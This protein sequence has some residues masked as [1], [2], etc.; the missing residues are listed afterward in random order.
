MW[1]LSGDYCPVGDSGVSGPVYRKT[2]FTAEE[3]YYLA[4]YHS[5][6]DG[7]I[8]G[9][10]SG[11]WVLKEP[12]PHLDFEDRENNY[13]EL[14]GAVRKC[15]GSKS[16]N[17][18]SSVFES[19]HK[20]LVLAGDQSQSGESPF[21]Q[22][23]GVGCTAPNITFDKGDKEEDAAADSEQAAE[24]IVL[25]DP[26]TAGPAD[27]WL[28]PCECFPESWGAQKPVSP[29]SLSDIPAGSGNKFVPARFQILEGSFTCEQAGLLPGGRGVLI[30]SEEESMQ[31][32]DCEILCREDKDCNYYWTGEVKSTK[33][34]RLFKR[35]S[36]LI[37][38]NG[39]EGSLFALPQASKKYCRVADPD[40][41]W[42]TTKR[43]EH[44]GASVGAK[45]N[46]PK[47][48]YEHLVMQCDQKLLLGGVGI[49]MCS[50]CTYASVNSHKW[51]HKHTLPTH[52]QHGQTLVAN[53]WDERFASVPS[54]TGKL[55]KEKLKCV[56]GQWLGSSGAPGLAGFACGACVQL[57]PSPYRTLDAQ[58]KQELYFASL[59]EV[60][61]YIDSK[62]PMQLTRTGS[63]ERVKATPKKKKQ[64]FTPLS[65]LVLGDASFF[66]QNGNI[67]NLLTTDDEDEGSSALEPAGSEVEN[68]DTTVDDDEEVMPSEA[69][70]DEAGS[71]ANTSDHQLSLEQEGHDEEHDDGDEAG[72]EDTNK[73]ESEDKD[74]DE[75]AD[76]NED[77]DRDHDEGQVEDDD[78]GDDE[79]EGGDEDDEDDEDSDE[80]SDSDGDSDSEPSTLA[81]D[82]SSRADTSASAV[83][84][85]GFLAVRK[86]SESDVESSDA[87]ID[88][89]SEGRRRRRRRRKSVVSKVLGGR[90]RRRRKGSSAKKKSKAGGKKTKASSKDCQGKWTPWDACS[91]SCGG[92]KQRSTYIVKKT[93]SRGGKKCPKELVKV[94]Q[95][96]MDPCGQHAPGGFVPEVVPTVAE[97]LKQFESTELVGRCL[98]ADRKEAITTK[99]CSATSREQLI[100]ASSILFQKFTSSS[101]ST[102]PKSTPSDVA[103]RRRTSRAVYLND[104]V[105][106]QDCKDHAISGLGFR[107]GRKL[108]VTVRCTAAS[109]IGAPKTFRVPCLGGD[110][111]ASRRDGRCVTYDPK[112]SSMPLLMKCRG[113]RGQKWYWSGENLKSEGDGSK[114]LQYNYISSRRRRKKS[115]NIHMEKCSSSSTKWY[116]EEDK[117]RAKGSSKCL[118]YHTDEDRLSNEN[119]ENSDKQ[120]WFIDNGIQALTRTPM[121]CP[122]GTVMS[123][124]QKSSTRI[125]YKCSVVADLGGC[126]PGQTPQVD[127]SS[128]T[129]ENLKNMYVP[130]GSSHGVSGLVAEASAAGKWLRFR[131]TCC[132]IGGLPIALVPTG[133]VWG[134][135]MSSWEGVYCPSSRTSGGRLSFEQRSA[136][137]FGAKPS[138]KFVFDERFGKW[139]VGEDCVQS[140]QAHPLDAPLGGS[141]WQAVRVSDFDGEFAAKGVTKAAEED[142]KAPPQLIEF[143][144]T[145]PQYAEECKD[146]VMPDTDKFD[147]EK[148]FEVSQGLS[149]GNPCKLVGGKAPKK[150]GDAGEGMAY[151][152]NDLDGNEGGQGGITYASVLGCQARSG[153]RNRMVGSVERYS[154]L[155]KFAATKIHSAAGMLCAAAPSTMIAPLGIGIEINIPKICKSAVDFIKTFS[156]AAHDWAMFGLKWAKGAADANDCGF[157]A[158]FAARTFCDLHCI[159]DAVTSGDKATLT[160]LEKAV[161]VIGQ[162]TQ[163]LMEHFTGLTTEK[164]DEVLENQA[165]ADEESALIQTRNAR[166][167]ILSMLEEMKA[168]MSSRRL[169]VAGSTTV[170]RALAN[171]IT[172]FKDVAEDLRAQQNKTSEYVRPVLGAVVAHAKNLRSAVDQSMTNDGLGNAESAYESTLDYVRTTTTYL[173]SEASLLGTYHHSS[174]E[175]KESQ[176]LLRSRWQAHAE[177]QLLKQFQ[178]ESTQWLLSDLDTTWWSLRGHLDEYLHAFS[179][180]HESLK[181]TTQVLE[182]YTSSCT[183]GFS[184]LQPS[185]RKVVGS[186]KRAHAVLRSTWAASV[187]LVGLIAAKVVD[188]DVFGRLARADVAAE[189]EFPGPDLRRRICAHNATAVSDQVFEAVGKGLFF[190]TV[191]QLHVAFNAMVMLKD[192]FVYGG[193]GEPDDADTVEAAWARVEA[194]Y[195]STTEGLPSL[196]REAVL[197]AVSAASDADC[198]HH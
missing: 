36:F 154:K 131:Y 190:Q 54:G 145:Q 192:R 58:E 168:S 184:A 5:D 117:L 85:S 67:S 37:R 39:I 29:D 187:P 51:S 173:R 141:S 156:F 49:E 118:A 26:S 50:R 186:E 133:N 158:H 74:T 160:S 180:Q 176:R 40:R 86:S 4:E 193:L 167:Q 169:S 6:R 34:C 83:R 170:K 7:E 147:A 122:P 189:I 98:A 130:C 32:A 63:L 162:N 124:L 18:L 60:Q 41:C 159:R 93:P 68:D 196:V 101:A 128:E 84:R 14:H 108:G 177:S 114:C 62:T 91:K 96:G 151:W 178:D 2:G 66:G 198:A 135:K 102:V 81:A 171:F 82:P 10:K 78:E 136:F 104:F 142:G 140:G 163:I 15:L 134:H 35:C 113:E 59:R 109:V 53:C 9:C 120:R 183:V 116:W 45:T 92:G 69:A 46:V 57:V 181:E 191:Q 20:T 48:A 172:V 175:S 143:G 125:T 132:A 127:T 30:E 1:Y 137:K 17:L 64:P 105:F 80:D 152:A 97:E 139:C 31:P 164:L 76:E 144:A 24:I 52:F 38:E 12:H 42:K 194:S 195:R 150:K 8:P 3:S 155:A 13:I 197:H 22:V 188:E 166:Q 182:A 56:S 179:A 121:E 129:L 19:G 11:D 43:R 61:V 157:N 44:L 90:R 165:E 75:D 94:R 174:M 106:K 27:H 23:A 123:F 115:R 79:G 103:R 99:K 33:Q 153:A 100:E 185:F 65:M 71:M 138:M 88:A 146:E 73:D 148:Q 25:D 112:K 126:T 55:S 110:V 28:H 161:D 47:C 119:C 87:V 77:T 107:T 72:D 89:D 149:E 70:Q 21:A 16:D 95:C 111:W